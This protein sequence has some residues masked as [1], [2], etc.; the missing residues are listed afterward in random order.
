MSSDEG[1]TKVLFICVHNSARSQIAEEYLRKYG[2]DLF[3]VESAGL[4]PGELNPLVVKALQ[5]DGIDIAGK[6]T[7][8]V[9]DMYRGGN[10]YHYV[11]TVCSREA[12]Q[13]CPIFPGPGEKWHWP[14]P[15]PE[16]FE[17]TDDEVLQKI[18]EL[19]NVLRE[20]IKQFVNAFKN[21]EL[22]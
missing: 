7:R 4:E 13:R 18:R 5:E 22:V 8:S 14:Y 15:D 6:K 19:R 11:I 9:W 1:K 20:Q 2:G 3:H 17:G 12:E 10:V 21:K 16:K